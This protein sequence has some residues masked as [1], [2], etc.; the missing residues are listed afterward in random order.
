M[1][2]MFSGLLARKGGAAAS[3]RYDNG[4]A[5]FDHGRRRIVLDASRVLDPR[6]A[7]PADALADHAPCIE[8][9][10]ETQSTAGDRVDWL[11]V[12]ERERQASLRLTAGRHRVAYTLRLTAEQHARLRFMTAYETRPAQQIMIDAL[13]RYLA[14]AVPFVLNSR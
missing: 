13:E 10:D 3:Q 6:P 11:Q 4:I 9:E 1:S 7:T 12:L 2:N 14:V 5:D 8:V